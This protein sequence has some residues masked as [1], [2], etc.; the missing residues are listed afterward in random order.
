MLLEQACLRLEDHVL[1]TALLV[2]VMNE[3]QLAGHVQVA[4]RLA[5]ARPTPPVG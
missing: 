4:R 5:R 1:P 2:V 3:E